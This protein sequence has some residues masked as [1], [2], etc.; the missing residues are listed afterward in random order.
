MGLYVDDFD[1][2]SAFLKEAEKLCKV[3]VIDYNR[4]EKVYDN[5]TA[6][7]TEGEA[8]VLFSRPVKVDTIQASE[9]TMVI[10]GANEVS[11]YVT[12]HGV[13]TGVPY[14]V[15]ERVISRSVPGAVL[16]RTISVNGLTLTNPLNSTN[17]LDRLFTYYT[18]RRMVST[19]IAVR[20]EKPGEL[21]RFRDPYGVETTGFIRNMEW[22]TSG[23]TKADCEIVANYS[24]AGISTNMQNVLLLTGEGEWEVPAAIRERDNPYIRAVIIG[25]GQGGHGGYSGH[26]SENRPDSPGEGGGGGEGGE[27][28]KVLTA[29]INVRDIERSAY[30]CGK[31]GAGGQSDKEGEKGTDTLFG[32]Y[33]SFFGAIIGGGI[34][35]MIDRRVSHSGGA[36]FLRQPRRRSHLQG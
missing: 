7:H 6:P 5:S 33:N 3:R 9:P 16:R 14:Q 32:E 36:G 27:G 25:G 4:S 11:A 18:T 26:S 17:L 35:N 2:V 24:P 12:G 19:S 8:L 21:Y 22:L 28:G 30:Y 29:E 13:I 15:Q 34:L 1:K 23:I 31:G 20:D 10:R